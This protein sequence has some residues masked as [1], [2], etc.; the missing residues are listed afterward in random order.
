MGLL[1]LFSCSL[2]PHGLQHT[3]LPCPSLAPGAC[4]NSCPLNWWYHPTISSSVTLFSS[5][6]QSSQH[7]GLFQWVGSL[8]Q[9][10]KVLEL[11]HQSFQWIFWVDFLY[12]WLVWSPCCSRNSQ[13]SSPAPKFE[14]I[15]SSALSLLYGP[16]HS[17]MTMGK[18][19]ALTIWTFISK[20]MSLLFNVVPRFVVEFLPRGKCLLISWL[21]SLSAVILESKKIKQLRQTTEPLAQW[22]KLSTKKAKIFANNLSDNSYNSVLENN[23]MKKWAEGLNRNFSREDTQVANRHMKNVQH[24]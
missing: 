12:D 16:S 11:Q 8:H 4:S 22:R 10:A 19:M 1:L 6:I 17:Y 21:H 15:N 18:T 2:W 14:R 5:C 24:H 9:V 7:Q 13:E 3:R 20:V 23:L